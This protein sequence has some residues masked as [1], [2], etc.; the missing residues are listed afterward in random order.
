[1]AHILKPVNYTN[2]ELIQLNEY[3]FDIAFRT[4]KQFG[5]EIGEIVVGKMR[6]V[7]PEE[8]ETAAY[9]EYTKLEIGPCGEFGFNYTN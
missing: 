9:Y 3:G 8:G 5:P 6:R 1:M 2:P 4:E 7:I